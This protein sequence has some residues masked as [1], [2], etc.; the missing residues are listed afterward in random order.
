MT[1]FYP[2]LYQQK[3]GTSAGPCSG[4]HYLHDRRVQLPFLLNDKDDGAEEG[5]CLE[6]TS[7]YCLFR[8]LQISKLFRECSET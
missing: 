8:I 4:K 3:L 6:D 7:A 1:L 2:E 5:P